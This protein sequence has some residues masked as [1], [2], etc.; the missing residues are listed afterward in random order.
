MALHIDAELMEPMRLD[1]LFLLISNIIIFD[2]VSC[3]VLY[4]Q[5][6]YSMVFLLINI[7]NCIACIIQ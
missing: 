7:D 5:D 3:D 1:F 6:D 4:V 2:N